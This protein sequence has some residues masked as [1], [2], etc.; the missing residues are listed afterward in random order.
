M[1]TAVHRNCSSEAHR[2][3]LESSK[4]LCPLAVDVR[5]KLERDWVGAGWSMNVIL[6]LIQLCRIQQK[7]TQLSGSRHASAQDIFSRKPSCA[8][9]V[10]MLEF[11]K[12]GA[13]TCA[14]TNWE[15]QELTID[16]RFDFLANRLCLTTKLR[17]RNPTITVLQE[18]QDSKFIGEPCRIHILYVCILCV[19][20]HVYIYI[21]IYT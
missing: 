20:I 3:S 10:I 9:S 19:Y 1:T 16:G 13:L 15:S 7:A 6:Q 14:A 2:S 12:S 8:T 17:E 18:K 21:C 11:K 4:P 5:W